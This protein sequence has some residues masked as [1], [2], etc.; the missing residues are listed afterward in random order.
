MATKFADLKGNEEEDDPSVPLPGGDDA[1][2]DLAG[3]KSG[4]IIEEEEVTIIDDDPD[5]TRRAAEDDD[6]SYV[7]DDGAEDGKGKKLSINE[8]LDRERKAKDKWRGQAE[9]AAKE[10]AK[11]RSL[12]GKA[13]V[14]AEVAKLEAEIQ[15]AKD[16][17]AAAKFDTGPDA[18]EKADAALLKA[19]TLSAELNILKKSMATGGDDV[20]LPANTGGG[21][22]PNRLAEKWVER[23]DSW[24][25]DERF[26]HIKAAVQAIDR[27]LAKEG[28]LETTDPQYFR[29][30]DRRVKAAGIKI[31]NSAGGGD[32]DDDRSNG[33]S[34]GGPARVGAV[35]TG[36]PQRRNAGKTLTLTRSDQA[37]MRVF[38]L[39]PKD[40]KHLVA[41]AREKNSR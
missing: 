26:E 27:K 18:E 22:K 2:D 9:A 41:F 28:D 8:R 11:L 30:L 40:P 39:N 35:A 19:A 1:I 4:P 13:S 16:E 5:E 12:V 25:G 32:R 34:R 36:G 7:D 20:D 21:T 24:W 10:N 31:P 15:K 37:R 3:R 38:G 29:E 23:N 6:D 33:S 17:R 14:N